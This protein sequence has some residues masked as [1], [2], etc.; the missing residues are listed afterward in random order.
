MY[1]VSKANNINTNWGIRELREGVV[2][3]KTSDQSMRPSISNLEPRT[4]DHPD[5][6]ETH[7]RNDRPA[8]LAACAEFTERLGL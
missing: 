6:K 3:E 2:K 1:V 7:Y 4:S 5:A 8:F